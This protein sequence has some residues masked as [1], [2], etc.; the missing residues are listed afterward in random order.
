MLLLRHVGRWIALL[1]LMG[2]AVSGADARSGVV[3]LLSSS[4]NVMSLPTHGVIATIAGNVSFAAKKLSS[5][6]LADSIAVVKPGVLVVGEVYAH[7]V[8]LVNTTHLVTKRFGRTALPHSMIVVAGNDSNAD[9]GDGNP[10]I[11]A[12]FTQIQ[13]IALDMQGNLYIADTTSV[14][15]VDAHTGIVSAVAG[16]DT[17]GFSGD[18]GLATKAQL[19]TPSGLAFDAHGNLYI[20]DYDNNRVRVVHASNGTITTVAGTGTAGFSGDGRLATMAALNNPAAVAVSSSG[21]LYISDSGNNRVRAVAAT[22]HT[23]STIVGTGRADNNGDGGPAIHA[24]LNSPVALALDTHGDLLIADSGNN[25]IRSLNLATGDIGTIG[26]NGSPQCV[27]YL[28]YDPPA[29]CFSGDGSRAVSATLRDPQAVAIDSSG[30]IFVADYGNTRVR[31][32]EAKTHVMTT[33]VGGPYPAD[34]NQPHAALGV[35]IHPADIAVD[36]RGDVYFVDNIFNRVQRVNPQ[37]GIATTIAGT[38]VRGYSGDGRLAVHASMN[39]PSG[40]A[41]DASGNVYIADEN[42][43][44]IREVTA[45][46]GI[47]TT[48][49]GTGTPGTRGDGGKATSAS[50]QALASIAVNARGDVYF[51]D[52]NRVRRIDAAT[53]LITTVAGRI[54]AGFAGDH[55]LATSALLRAPQGIALDTAGNLYIADTGNHRLRAVNGNTGVIT[56]LAGTGTAGSAGDKGLAV[57]AQLDGPSAVKLDGAGDI[58]IADEN[59]STVREISARSSVITLVAGSS[60]YYGTSGDGGLATQATLNYPVGL[61]LDQAGN[62]YIADLDNHRI[63]VVGT[64]GRSVL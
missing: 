59:A 49:A 37:T 26:G 12:A 46:T 21:V 33:V 35:S 39:N 42:N 31:E 10:A 47:I 53:G 57:L 8:W 2:S 48:I 25:R 52:A 54:P 29:H 3:D 60:Q 63:R 51:T 11:H 64:V 61:G 27:G 28:P 6:V 19:S 4:T 30:N 22:S 41:V 62:L 13:T 5:A 14:R 56:T 43:A 17:M 20:A 1:L 15:K 45:V 40:I 58:F 23:I 24:D 36:A 44:V 16:N 55:G 38:G 32:I 18:G 9:Y 7:V 34:G 50:L